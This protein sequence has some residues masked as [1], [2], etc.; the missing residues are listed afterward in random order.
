MKKKKVAVLLMGI[1]ICENLGLA[2]ANLVKAASS[3]KTVLVKLDKKNPKKY[4]T[5][6]TTIKKVKDPE[7]VKNY[8]TYYRKVG[9][10]IKIRIVSMKGKPRE[11]TFNLFDSMSKGGK[12][13]LIFDFPRK[14]FVRGVIYNDHKE[15]VH[16]GNTKFNMDLAEIKGV[17]KIT[18]KITITNPARKKILKSVKV[19]KG[20]TLCG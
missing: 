14:K 4:V 8:E 12:G 5:V 11:K 9:V 17:S 15:M 10:S 1:L 20:A 7:K 3:Q 13:Y 19:K 2:D 18:Y 16:A 6:K